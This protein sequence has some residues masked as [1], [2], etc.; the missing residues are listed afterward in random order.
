MPFVTSTTGSLGAGRRNVPEET[1][2]A[3]IKSYY[4]SNS[5]TDGA[6]VSGNVSA[7]FQ[8]LNYAISRITDQNTI[9]FVDGSYEFDEQTISTTG[10]TLQAV[11]S[12][13]VTF[14]GTRAI[15]DLA[16]TSV[17]NGNWQ[18]HTTT[19]VTDTNQTITNKTIYKIKLKS[20]AEIWQLFHNRNEVI[21]ARYPSAQWSDESVYSFDNWGHGYYDYKNNGDIEDSNGTVLGNGV[22]SHYYYDNGE[23]VDVAHDGIDL[24]DFVTTQQGIDS[25]FTLANSLINLNVGSFKSYTK[26]VNSQ[27][28]DSANTVIRLGYD[29]VALWKE[30]HHYYYLENKLEFLNSANEWYFDNSTK[31]LYVWLTSDAVPNLQNIRAKT[32]SYSLNVTASNVAVKDINFFATTVKG[33]N[34]DNLLV[35]DCNFMYASC[36]AHMLDQINY[37]SNI[38]PSSNEVFTTQTY[39]NSSSNVH[40][41]GCVFRYTDG[42]VIHVSGGNTTVEDCYFNYIDKTVCNLSS[43]MTTFRLMGS[44]NTIKNNTIHK[45][46]ASSTLNPGNQ[47]IIEYNNL[48]ESG[49]LQ[50][51]GAMIHLMVAQ[52][53]NTKVRFN[54]VHDTIKYGIRC[55]GDGDGYNA[56]IHHNVGWNC[57]GG[58]M[59]KG[60][61]LSSNVSVGGHFVYNN[62]MFN[63]TVKNDIMV[64]NEQAGENIN[65]GSVVLNNLCE[66]LS[67][68]RTNAEAFESRIINS[69]NLTPS[70]VEV[71]LANA[72]SNVYTPVSNV[73]TV[74]AGNIT[75]SNSEFSPTG[76][77]ALTSDI[78][79]MFYFGNFWEAGITWNNTTSS[80]SD[81]VTNNRLNFTYTASGN[82]N[83]YPVNW[84]PSDLSSDLVMWINPSDTSTTVF[85]GSNIL[86]SVQDASGNANESIS[87]NNSPHKGTEDSKEIIVFD[88]SSNEY[89]NTGTGLNIADNGNHWALFAGTIETANN[90]KDSIFSFDTAQSPARDYA[91]SAG[92]SSQFDGELD[93]DGLSNYRI[94]STIGNKQEFD[95][96]YPTISAN[97][98][99]FLL[100]YFDKSGNEIGARINGSDA[101]TP[102]SDYDYS[103]QSQAKMNIFRNRGSQSFGGKLF[104]FMVSD[105]QPGTGSGDKTHIEKAEGYIAHKWGMASLLPNSH[106]YKN[107]APSS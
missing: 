85:N 47:A 37:G 23:I 45:T 87:I 59:A 70:N 54:W 10:L 49:Y 1:T 63:S 24:Y 84:S 107:S 12:G 64:L 72:S 90:T 95:T 29:N 91:V 27:T 80:D 94:S 31:Y 78:G 73:S 30:K 97:T 3:E 41:N 19:I 48:S 102:V 105:G 38:N 13:N 57:E 26:V 88:H 99:F 58:I 5:G 74:N 56:Y 79:A 21:N 71:Y 25:N 17:N 52:Q 103:I 81:Y 2:T 65:Y 43:V 67:G 7:P 34:A 44:N 101:F 100:V 20:D 39:I 76:V 93:L 96:P 22:S 104:E 35:K 8:T 42:D 16:D 14:D 32:Q 75:Y 92:N 60:G 18:T 53:A 69:N 86:T 40:I 98:N 46:A 11:N 50:S 83:S 33:N 28:L 89:L 36:Y 62:T 55:D 61:I 6:S 106:P 51:D 66:T 15:Y 82:P 77:D 68:H 9:Y 4:V